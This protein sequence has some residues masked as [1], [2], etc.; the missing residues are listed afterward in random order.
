[1][2]YLFVKPN[3]ITWADIIYDDIVDAKYK[4]LN[5]SKHYVYTV[6]HF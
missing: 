2:C 5:D 1:M 3:L 6:K 4:Q